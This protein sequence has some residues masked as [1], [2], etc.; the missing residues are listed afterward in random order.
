MSKNVVW[1]Q[2]K[3]DAAKAIIAKKLPSEPATLYQSAKRP[4]F[5]VPEPSVLK[6]PEMAQAVRDIGGAYVEAGASG[7][8]SWSEV[9][10][11]EVPGISD[12]DL[13][14]TWQ[15]IKDET[16]NRTRAKQTAD[17]AEVAV[18]RRLNTTF[19]DGGKKILAALP[20]DMHDEIVRKAGAGEKFSKDEND[21]VVSAFKTAR[22]GV[23]PNSAGRFPQLDAAFRQ[24]RMDIKA[25]EDAQQR[26]AAVTDGKAV[27]EDRVHRAFEA[28]ADQIKRGMANGQTTSPKLDALAARKATFDA[29]LSAIPDTPERA[30][31]RGKVEGA[32]GLNATGRA[33]SQLYDKYAPQGVGSQ[34]ADIYRGGELSGIGTLGKVG[35]SHY[36]TQGLE[37][38]IVRAIE[39]LVP[40]H[41]QGWAGT[42]R[43]LL[44]GWHG[45]LAAPSKLL[46]GDNAR[47]LTGRDPLH[48]ST[49][50]LSSEYNAFGAPGPIGYASR[51]MVKGFSRLHG[52]IVQPGMEY[53]FSEGLSRAA[54]IEARAAVKQNPK[55]DYKATR[56]DLTKKPT[57]E[58]KDWALKNALE[59]TFRNDN[60]LTDAA[61]K[62][63]DA[64]VPVAPFMKISS[65]LAG[66][67]L[68][69]SVPG[70]PVAYKYLRMIG[71]NKGKPLTP[72]QLA[73]G[74]R[75]VARNVVGTVGGG[76]LG[77][78]LYSTGHI[79]PADPKNHEWGSFVIGGKKYSSAL[80]G[81]YGASM[82]TGGKL[83]QVANETGKSG[84]HKFGDVV[85]AYAGAATE[86]PLIGEGGQSAQ[87]LVQGGKG[88]E[89]AIG[90]MVNP[91]PVLAREIAAQ[92]DTRRKIINANSVGDVIQKGVPK[93]PFN[94]KMNRERLPVYLF[95]DPNGVS[96]FPYTK[97]TSEDKRDM[98]DPK[99]QSEI[100]ARLIR[101]AMA[102]KK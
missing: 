81:P 20:P 15:S 16:F 21:A 90:N 71:E 102:G 49:Q 65:N 87:D 63:K 46:E 6:D 22:P 10:R 5:G 39:G 28:Q 68:E 94:P 92:Q 9:M 25:Q 74:A 75:V 7:W 52:A 41:A 4:G 72:Y 83:E 37:T 95:P 44:A 99:R 88:A 85:G 47:I 61:K 55:L 32:L 59:A 33:L 80:L 78:Y 51:G 96:P 54:E 29:A 18:S 64:L 1:D 67:S 23:K 50:P 34:I 12:K 24:A 79:I 62:Y 8:N 35:S 30:S 66:R 82:M 57:P 48:P 58:M 36:L 11:S 101:H 17:E 86:N 84:A 76:A 31:V 13:L 26:W 27:V 60:I 42:G 69:T 38:S 93:M 100:I 45:I 91:V 43:A 77:A 97:V 89:K 2:S 56:D 98:A 19:G 40:G 73:E 3:F 14:S 53:A 70:L